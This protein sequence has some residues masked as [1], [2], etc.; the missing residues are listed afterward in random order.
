M[1]ILEYGYELG[2][3]SRRVFRC[4]SSVPNRTGREQDGLQTSAE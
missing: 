3:V 2:F 4:L 1:N